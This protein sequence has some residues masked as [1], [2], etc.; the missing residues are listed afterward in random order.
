MDGALRGLTVLRGW[1]WSLPAW[2]WTSRQ[3][4]SSDHN[5]ES[6]HMFSFRETMTNFE[7]DLMTKREMFL[8]VEIEVTLVTFSI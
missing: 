1:T 2:E 4:W 5:R 3:W 6:A 7:S 8:Q